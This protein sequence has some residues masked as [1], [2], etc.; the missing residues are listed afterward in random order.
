VLTGFDHAFSFAKRRGINE[1]DVLLFRSWIE[2]VAA[3]DTFLKE[4]FGS[5]V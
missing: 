2:E 4:L 3:R 1:D 5:Y